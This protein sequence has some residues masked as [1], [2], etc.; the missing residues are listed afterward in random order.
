MN[1]IKKN[2]TLEKIHSYF[3]KSL[4]KADL[5]PEFNCAIKVKQG[6]NFILSLYLFNRSSKG[7]LPSGVKIL[8]LNNKDIE[9][10]PYIT[11]FELEPKKFEKI[12]IMCKAPMKNETYKV[13]FILYHNNASIECS[14]VTVDLIVGMD[15]NERL[16]EF[17]EEF[18]GIV[19]LPKERKKIIFDVINNEISRKSPDTIRKIL[20]KYKWKVE[21]ALDDLM[22]D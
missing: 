17:F 7:N 8:P 4:L 10:M 21:F 9:I 19:K 3:K 22:C 6:K 2:E 1:K 12:E 5:E 18:E 13:K 14:G 20:E 16:N 11:N 15:E